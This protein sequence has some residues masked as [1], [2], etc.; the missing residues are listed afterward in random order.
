MPAN[1]IARQKAVRIPE[2]V[3][4]E[5]KAEIIRE[6]QQ[7]GRKDG[8]ARALDGHSHKTT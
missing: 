5:H 7:G 2:T 3:W 8:V 4:N 1:Q 6:Y